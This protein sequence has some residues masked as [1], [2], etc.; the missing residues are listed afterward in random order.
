MAQNTLSKILIIG[1]GNPDRQDDGAAWHVLTGLA[2]HWGRNL[3]KWPEEYFDPCGENP[4]ML[5]NLQLMPEIADTISK[6]D[7][8]CFVDAHTGNVPDD[9]NIVAIQP[10]FQNSPFTH[11]MT[12]E[13]CLSLVNEIYHSKPESLLV[14]VRGFQFG[15][16]HELSA[17]TGALVDQA[18]AAILKWIED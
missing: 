3:P 7:R 4:D 9:L 12:P 8:V 5:F 15:F 10:Q 14:S 1:Y 2:R 6:Y 16:D 11:H 17:E 18:V 13:T